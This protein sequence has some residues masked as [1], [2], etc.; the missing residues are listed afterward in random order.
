MEGGGTGRGSPRLPTVRVLGLSVCFFVCFRFAHTQPFGKGGSGKH[1]SVGPVGGAAVAGLAALG[2]LLH[3]VGL[4]AL[5]RTTLQEK[6]SIESIMFNT[7]D[8]HI[9][10]ISNEVLINTINIS[11]KPLGD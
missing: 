8:L 7:N 11:R 6:Q 3:A 1:S 10:S 4:T 5:T 2:L 9:Y